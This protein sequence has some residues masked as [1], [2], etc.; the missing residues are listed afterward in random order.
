M[1]T[2]LKADSLNDITRA[3]F[4]ALPVVCGASCWND[5]HCWAQAFAY[6]PGVEMARISYRTT[7]LWANVRVWIKGE[8]GSRV[9]KVH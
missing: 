5:W 1:A 9:I 2:I 7:G 6:H 4:N 8:H 3:E